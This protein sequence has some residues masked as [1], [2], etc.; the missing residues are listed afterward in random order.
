MDVR[1]PR[2][3]NRTSDPTGSGKSSTSKLKPRTADTVPTIS[4]VCMSRSD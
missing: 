2:V 4:S 1:L 3:D